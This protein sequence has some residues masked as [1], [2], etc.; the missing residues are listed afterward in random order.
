MAALRSRLVHLG[1]LLLAVGGCAARVVAWTAHERGGPLLTVE[2]G[3]FTDR[4]TFGVALTDVVRVRPTSLS[5]S[6][7]GRWAAL[8]GATLGG[9]VVLLGDGKSEPRADGTYSEV[10]ALAVGDRGQVLHGAR[11]DGRW[12]AVF[13]QP[14][15][16]H[17][18]P[19]FD[20]IR[21]VALTPGGSPAYVGLRRGRHHLHVAGRRVLSA[22]ALVGTALG[23]DAAGLPRWAAIVG[24]ASGYWAIAPEGRHGPHPAFGTA[25]VTRNGDAVFTVRTEP[26]GPLHLLRMGRRGTTLRET[27][28]REM[29]PDRV[30]A[31]GDRGVVFVARV[32]GGERLIVSDDDLLSGPLC[33][34]VTHLVRTADEVAYSC[35]HGPGEPMTLRLVTS[36]G[37]E[38]VADVHAVL[39]L[40]LAGGRLF[41]LTLV[42]DRSGPTLSLWADGIE[43]RFGTRRD[44]KPLPGGFAFIAGRFWVLAASSDGAP[45]LVSEH[46]IEASLAPA[47]V[48]AYIDGGSGAAAIIGEALRHGVAPTA[49]V[50]DSAPSR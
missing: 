43:R 22:T 48:D 46:G 9:Q 8:Q 49:D 16:T 35:E 19:A 6:P 10:G 31:F 7:N 24:T 36:R 50:D 28:F 27:P 38:R 33:R 3:P 12:H 13:R 25:L 44:V 23:D 2:R 37:D 30:G 41:A 32:D 47:W 40:G 39:E 26:R 45:V 42:G 18:G 11:L 17:V 20:A 34:R 15:G 14:S 29:P 5:M 4:V 21:S 1:L